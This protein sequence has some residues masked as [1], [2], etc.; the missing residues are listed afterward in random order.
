MAAVCAMCGKKPGYG[1]NVSFSNRKTNRRWMPNLQ[2]RHTTLNGVKGK[3]RICTRC[4]RTQ[5]KHLA[6]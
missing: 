1:H 3:H 5:I 4:L 6:A 2:V